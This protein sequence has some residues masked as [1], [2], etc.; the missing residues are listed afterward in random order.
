MLGL[1]SP[2]AACG[3]DDGAR[4]SGFSGTATSATA[5]AGTRGTAGGA[6]SNASVGGTAT[7]TTTTAGSTN[8]GTAGSTTGTGSST[9]GTSTGGGM[10]MVTFDW[11]REIWSTSRYDIPLGAVVSDGAVYVAGIRS[12]D[13]DILGFQI[14]NGKQQFR[15]T[16]HDLDTGDKLAQQTADCTGFFNI[17]DVTHARDIAADDAG[18]L[19]VAGHARC[20]EMKIGFQ[21]KD[22][23]V[24]TELKGDAFVISMLPTL[25]PRWIETQQSDD[26]DKAESIAVFGSSVV[27]AGHFSGSVL[28][29][30]GI[31][32][33]GNKGNFDV[34][35]AEYTTDGQ[36]T[37]RAVGIGGG[38]DDGQPAVTVGP[39]GDIYV[40][41]YM[42]SNPT[43]VYDPNGSVLATIAPAGGMGDAFVVK[44][45]PTFDVV[46]ATSIGGPAD[47]KGRGIVADGQ[48]VYVAGFTEGGIDL[49]GCCNL[50]PQ[51]GK[52]A[53][54]VVLSDTD[55]TPMAGALVGGAGTD[56]FYDL[57]RVPDTGRVFAAG[58]FSETVEA[59]AFSLVSSGGRDAFTVAFDEGAGVVFAG[60]AQGPDKD[61]AKVVAGSGSYVLVG[62]SFESK[63]WTVAGIDLPGMG[64]LSDAFLL[65]MTTSAP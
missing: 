56:Q 57:A 28:D 35:V 47:D 24:N 33:L 20:Q 23:T 34:Y 50:A 55:G 15:I 38:E 36:P 58:S 17:A 21:G 11:V 19:Y 45:S 1:V 13:L 64:D 16:K 52:D 41:G 12:K 51:G 30:K 59:G 4:T 37:G 32:A 61:E 27:V 65:R 8:T 18:N 53:Y 54:L 62:G 49:P 2:L 29:I 22:W 5:T 48:R 3:G 31:L 42:R 14:D 9:G 44:L 40:T 10:D 60:S 7:S 6:T 39:S 46:W 63:P 26:E 43:V 25:E